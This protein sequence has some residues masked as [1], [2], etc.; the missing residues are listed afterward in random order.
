MLIL[1]FPCKLLFAQNY[2]FTLLIVNQYIH[3]VA[4]LLMMF[5]K[6]QRYELAI[7]NSGAGEKDDISDNASFI[8]GL[9]EQSS[10]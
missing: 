3:I 1:C 7:K 9:N 5:I 4:L 6:I 2:G 8:A 10:S